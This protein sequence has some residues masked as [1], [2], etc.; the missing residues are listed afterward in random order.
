MVAWGRT[1]LAVVLLVAIR[2]DPAEPA[3]YVTA[4]NG[5][6]VSYT[7]YSAIALALLRFR[8]GVAPTLGPILHVL[9]LLWAFSLT[10]WTEGPGSYLFLLFVFAILSAAY[11]WGLRETLLTTAAA[12]VALTLEAAAAAQ[13]YTGAAFHLN[14]FLIRNAYLA[15]FGLF[16]GL[17]SER[18]RRLRREAAAIAGI[19]RQVRNVRRTCVDRNS[20]SRSASL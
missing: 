13:G 9:D 4:V 15:L 19:M 7:I 14:Y 8:P 11:R 1:V 18:E 3:R 16:L 6:L 10:L 20:R 2:L 17:L 5:L 12:I